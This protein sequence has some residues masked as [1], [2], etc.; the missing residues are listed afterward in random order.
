M[1]ELA[2]VF[3]TKPLDSKR[4]LS[5]NWIVDLPINF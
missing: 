2:Q 4:E 3:T 1:I 5:F